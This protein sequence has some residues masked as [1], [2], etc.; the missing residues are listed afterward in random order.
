MPPM[1]AVGQGARFLPHGRFHM[2]ARAFSQRGGWVPRRR[3]SKAKEKAADP[4]RFSLE[5]H[6]AT[7]ICQSQSQ[8]QFRIKG[9]EMDATS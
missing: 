3:I 1:R 7:S 4:L 6:S 5:N 2:A 9:K 8:G